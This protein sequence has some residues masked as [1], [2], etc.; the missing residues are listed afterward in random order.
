MA[1]DK[2]T[3]RVKRAHLTMMKHKDTALYSGVMLMGKTEVVDGQFTAY[4]DGVNKRYSRQFLETVNTEAKLRGLILHENLH[5]ALKQVM[6][7]KAMFKENPKLA[8]VAADL[9]V[10][11]VIKNITSTVKNDELLVE[12]PDGALYDP[13]FHNWSMRDIY[14][15]LRKENPEPE[16]GK[17]DGQSDGQSG[18]GNGGQDNDPQGGSTS[19]KKVV[20]NGQERDAEFDEHD[21]DGQMEADPEEVK[22]MHEA[23]DKALREGGILAGRLGGDIPKVIGE[24]LEPKVDWREALR[25]FV[26]SATRGKDELTWRRLN[27]RHIVNDFYLPTDVQD[28]VGEIVVAMDTSGSIG[29]QLTKFVA[30]LASICETCQPEKVRVLWWDYDVHGEQVFEDNYT[31]LVHMLKPQGGG[32]TRVTSV[33][34]YINK[35]RL[36]PDCVIVLTDGFVEGDVRW[37]VSSPTLWVITDYDFKP[38]AGKVVMLKD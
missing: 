22:K 9:V 38:K 28:S 4:T 27:K 16:K 10:N 5:I 34:E 30:E 35:H 20:I 31:N 23:V 3:M 26:T 36:E 24:L 6:H 21:F 13:E 25:E 1:D 33:S 14:R 37:E 12:L 11:D 19:S 8:N 32:G 17:G 29:H 7:G 15:H 18:D 2:Q